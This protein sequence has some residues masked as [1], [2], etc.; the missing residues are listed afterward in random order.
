MDAP[1]D[2]TQPDFNRLLQVLLQN[3]DFNPAQAAA[4]LQQE[5]ERQRMERAGPQPEQ[6]D[7]G[8]ENGHG[9]QEN[10][11]QPPPDQGQG[12]DQQPPPDPLPAPPRLPPAP[13]ER[14]AA[15]EVEALTFNPDK[16]VASAIQRRP[17]EYAIK[18][19]ETFKY[20]PL[21]YFTLEGLAEVARVLRQD[22]AKESLAL[23]QETG[24]GLSL[25]PTL[26]ISA[27]KFAK[28]DH[29][30]TF[31]KFLFAKNNFLTHFERAK[32]PGLVVDSFNWFF[33]NLE[34]HVL[35]QEESRGERVLLHYASRVRTN[36]HD[37]SPTERFNIAAIN[38]N[39]MSSIARE[40][41]SRDIGRGVAW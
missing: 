8:G 29:N 38:E 19:L 1:L 28:Y 9:P 6:Q 24:T 36:W 20:V 33:Y 31:S 14:P 22:D 34:T 26:S 2:P 10:Q 25:R 35:R 5:W 4:A 39:L 30:L 32:W 3:P 11:R 40:L 41:D 37:A 12:P 7:Q 17:S 18:C 27:S 13:E 21:W 23:T 16:T 15:K